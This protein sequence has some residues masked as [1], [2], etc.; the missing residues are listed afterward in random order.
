MVSG[1]V[2]V[3]NIERPVRLYL[4]GNFHIRLLF[5]SR[6]FICTDIIYFDVFRYCPSCKQHREASKTM[7][8]WKLPHTLI[9]QL[10]RFSFRNSMF[11]YAGSYREKID[12]MVDFPVR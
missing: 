7:S 5:N 2:L 1:I 12:K 10:K 9:I 3:V 8:V 4:S 6:D 11:T